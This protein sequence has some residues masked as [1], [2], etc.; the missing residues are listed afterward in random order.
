MKLLSKK[1]LHYN[2]LIGKKMATIMMASYLEIYSNGKIN[3]KQKQRSKSNYGNDRIFGC[4]FFGD[5]G[6]LSLYQFKKSVKG[7]KETRS[8]KIDFNNCGALKD[9]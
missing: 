1:S 9:R 7:I 8:P 6:I 3:L 2:H 5:V 4:R